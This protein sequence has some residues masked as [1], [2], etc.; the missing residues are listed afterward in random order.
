MLIG[1]NPKKTTQQIQDKLEFVHLSE[2]TF[3]Q[4]ILSTIELRDS[5][6][7]SNFIQF[8]KTELNQP[9][10]KEIALWHGYSLFHL[11]DYA[12]AIEVYEELLNQ[13]PS[14]TLLYLYISSCNFYLKDFDRA[15]ETA[16]KGPKTDLQT[17][18]IFYISHQV[19]AEQEMFHVHSQLFG[20][21]ENQLSFAAIH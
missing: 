20:T 7:T 8:L 14:D 11:G 18:L 2:E 6:A 19:G 9:Y 17:R 3:L 1:A 4:Q 5:S 21:L 13:D 12:S 16:L 10:T 15:K